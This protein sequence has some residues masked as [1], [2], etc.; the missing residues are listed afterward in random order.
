MLTAYSFLTST[1]TIYKQEKRF[2]SAL[3]NRKVLWKTR[4]YNELG[5]RQYLPEAQLMSLHKYLN[6][7]STFHVCSTLQAASRACSATAHS[8]SPS[9]STR[10]APVLNPHALKSSWLLSLSCTV[11]Q[12][13]RVVAGD[14]S[15]W[16]FFG[17]PGSCSSSDR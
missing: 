13:Q 11:L 16:P 1:H 17:A 4:F 10:Q 14:A 6:F 12:I 5:E 2:I 9:T 8:S 3:T 7:G 15:V